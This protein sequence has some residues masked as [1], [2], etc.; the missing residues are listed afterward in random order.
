ME[1]WKEQKSIGSGKVAFLLDDRELAEMN[2]D[3]E[4][5]ISVAKDLV[6][7]QQQ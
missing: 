1:W 7:V 4:V 2:E 6:P 5:T 3:K